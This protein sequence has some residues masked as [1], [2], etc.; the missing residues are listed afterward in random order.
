MDNFYGI[1]V[2]R[3]LLNSQELNSKQICDFKSPTNEELLNNINQ[4]KSIYKRSLI[5]ES[6][7]EANKVI[8]S[9]DTKSLLNLKSTNFSTN[10]SNSDLSFEYTWIENVP[11]D[12]YYQT[13]AH[14]NKVKVCIFHREYNCLTCEKNFEE[15]TIPIVKLYPKNDYSKKQV[16]IFY[17]LIEYEF[18][19][20]HYKQTMSNYEDYTPHFREVMKQSINDYYQEFINF[21]CDLDEWLSTKSTMETYARNIVLARSPLDAKLLSSKLIDIYRAKNGIYISS[22]PI[23]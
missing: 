10:S 6:R 7:N 5:T 11:S 16:D 4:L 17:V 15:F 22:K 18:L 3:G 20:L 19:L 8:A 21:G 12:E 9:S 23:I 14:G 1:K 13:D 2:M